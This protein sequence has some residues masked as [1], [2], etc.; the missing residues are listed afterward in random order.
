MRY[1]ENPE[2]FVRCSPVEVWSEHAKLVWIQSWPG[3]GQTEVLWKR[4]NLQMM[5]PTRCDRCSLLRCQR[6]VSRKLEVSSWSHPG[7][8]LRW[9]QRSRKVRIF[10]NYIEPKPEINAMVQI[11]PNWNLQPPVLFVLQY[12]TFESWPEL[13]IQW[14]KMFC[15]W[16][17]QR[18]SVR[19]PW[20]DYLLLKMHILGNRVR[21]L[22]YWWVWTIFVGP[23]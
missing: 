17:I 23:S 8:G 7:Q 13:S 14:L 15:Q 20:E 1:F 10:Q 22:K 11:S 16:P 9:S 21:I 6:L 18:P 5:F 3:I 2:I 19:H 4:F 12:S